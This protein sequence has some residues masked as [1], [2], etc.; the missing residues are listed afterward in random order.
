MNS[1]ALWSRWK[2]NPI[3]YCNE[4]ETA[5]L[6]GNKVQCRNRSLNRSENHKAGCFTD[7]DFR[8]STP[9]E[10]HFTRKTNLANEAAI[11]SLAQRLLP[12]VPQAQNYL[13]SMGIWGGY[14]PIPC[15]QSCLNDSVSIL[16]GPLKSEYS[17]ET[18]TVYRVLE[19]QTSCHSAF[20]PHNYTFYVHGCF[21]PFINIK[22]F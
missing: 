14:F 2:W 22:Q 18:W 20:T 19:T 3:Q 12:T 13:A 9:L 21:Q 10:R 1:I 15:I 16:K 17:Y 8:R 6:L 4:S 7:S 5:E 11:L